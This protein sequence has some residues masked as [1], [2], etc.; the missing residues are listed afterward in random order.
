MNYLVRLKTRMEE[1]GFPP[2][3]P[4][5]KLVAGAYDAMHRLSVETHYLS[6][7]GVGRPSA[8]GDDDEGD[9]PELP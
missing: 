3:D 2:A 5:Y 6:C 4:L 9:G 1:V 7:K 8:E